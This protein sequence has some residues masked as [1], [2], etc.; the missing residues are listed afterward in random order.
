[1]WATAAH[2][3]MW[4][5]GKESVRVI[6][7]SADLFP[8]HAQKFI[9]S[10][11]PFGMIGPAAEEFLKL[12]KYLHDKKESRD[13]VLVFDGRSKAVTQQMW[14]LQGFMDSKHASELTI[15]YNVTNPKKDARAVASKQK[16]FGACNRETGFV[17]LSSFGN[18]RP[19]IQARTSFNKCGESSTYDSTYPGVVHRHLSH[20]PRLSNE[21]H[22]AT[23]GPKAG[24]AASGAEKV[25]ERHLR[26]VQK[27]GNPAFW[28][29]YKPVDLWTSLFKSLGATDILDWT[30]GSGAAAAAALHLGIKYEGI[31]TNSSQRQWLDGLLDR[32]IYAVAVDSVEGAEAVGASPEFVNGIKLFFQGTVKE[33]RRFFMS[34]YGEGNDVANVD[35]DPDDGSSSDSSD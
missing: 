3:R 5:G 8:L 13:A 25:K 24:L 7:L 30:P 19:V 22:E 28:G 31:C 2:G 10:E 11:T 16:M 1:M 17:L 35:S 15:I 20:I 9:P 26:E 14:T 23:L 27:A 18:K 34:T 32:A 12:A 4:K 33:A 21:D 29:E 6:L